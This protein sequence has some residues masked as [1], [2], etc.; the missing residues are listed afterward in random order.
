[1]KLLEAVVLHTSNASSLCSLCA[2]IAV[3]VFIESCIAK[4]KDLEAEIC[5]TFSQ[6]DL[7]RDASICKMDIMLRFRLSLMHQKTWRR[8]KKADIPHFCSAL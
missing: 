1:M 4:P 6:Q 5:K 8:G 7:R 2:V 3:Q